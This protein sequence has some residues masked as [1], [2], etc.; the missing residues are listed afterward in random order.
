[1]F[2]HFKSWIEKAEPL[3]AVLQDAGFCTSFDI[4]C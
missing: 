2:P 3:T 1:M 4:L